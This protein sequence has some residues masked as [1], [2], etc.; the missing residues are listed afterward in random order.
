MWV[1]T[2]GYLWRQDKEVIDSKVLHSQVRK[3]DLKAK[4]CYWFTLTPWLDFISHILS[5]L[6]I[7]SLAQQLFIHIERVQEASE[8]G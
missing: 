4:P 2:D 1:L 7:N 3:P 6:I 5:S 8:L